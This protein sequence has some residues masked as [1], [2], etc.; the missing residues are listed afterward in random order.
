MEDRLGRNEFFSWQ[1]FR[2][3]LDAWCE[4]R[5]VV[6]TVRHCVLLNDD[7]VCREVAQALKYSS[8]DLG[9]GNCPLRKS[10]PAVIKLRL[11]LRKDRLIVIAANLQH[12]HRT[13]EAVPEQ[14]MKRNRLLHPAALAN[15]ISKKFLD[16]HDLKRLLRSPPEAF[17]DG[18]QV[19]KDL[20]SLFVSDPKA[21]VKLVFIEDKLLVK[22]IFVMVSYMQEV[23]QHF[24]ASLYVDLLPEFCKE[25]D[26]YTAFC[27]EDLSSWKICA[28]CIARKGTQGILRF[29]LVSI[30]Q[31]IPK[32]NTQVKHITLSPEILDP[33][34]LAALL[35]HASIRY[36]MPLVLDLLQQ[37]ISHPDP[38][39]GDEMKAILHVLLNT[40]SLEVYYQYL[41]DLK[42]IC[43]PELY[44]FYYDIWHSRRQMW[45][46][47]DVRTQV[48]EANIHALARWK[49]QAVKSQLCES[50]TLDQCLQVV[51]RDGDT[52]FYLVE[53]CQLPQSE[54]M[55]TQ[56]DALAET[57]EHKADQ[58]GDL[59]KEMDKAE[60]D[61]D[62]E[63][64]EE[65]FTQMNEELNV[66]V[67]QASEGTSEEQLEQSEFYSWVDF[68]SFLDAWCLERS[69]RFAI[70]QSVPLSVEKAG[71]VVAHS[72]KYETVSMGC[73]GSS[74]N[75]RK[76]CPATIHLNLGPQNDKLIVSKTYLWHNHDLKETSSFTVGA[77]QKLMTHARH[78]TRLALDI[79]RKF[80]EW[81]D[82]SRLLRFHS[83][84]FEEHSQILKELDSLFVSDP[85]I[86]VKL[87]F[88]EEQLLVKNIFIMTSQMQEL[89]RAFPEHL[90]VDF[91]PNLHPNFDLYTV[92]CEGENSH[93]VVCAYCISRKE[94]S[95][96]LRFSMVSIMQS[97]P[98]MS[99]QVKYVTVGP[100]VRDPQ[101][102]ETLV[103]NASVKYCVQLV[104]DRL[105]QS[106]A[107]V[108]SIIGTK[109]KKCV[110]NL[111]QTR[112][113]S[114]YNRYLN[115]LRAVCPVDI[116]NYYYSTWH[117][118]WKMWSRAD[119][120]SQDSESRIC[121]LV[122]AK[123]ERLTAHS[124]PSLHYCLQM[125]LHDC[126]ALSCLYL[127]ETNLNNASQIKSDLESPFVPASLNVVDKDHLQESVASKESKDDGCQP[128]LIKE[129]TEL[130]NQDSQQQCLPLAS[131][132]TQFLPCQET[133][134]HPAHETISHPAHESLP[135]TDIETLPHFTHQPLPLPDRGSMSHSL[136][137]P[138][139]QPTHDSLPPSDHEPLPPHDVEPLPPGDIAPLPPSDS[140]TM[141]P[142]Y[143]EPMIDSEQ[144]LQPHNDHLL[145]SHEVPQPFPSKKQVFLPQEKSPVV[146]LDE[147]PLCQDPQVLPYQEPQP[148]LLQEQSTLGS[149]EHEPRSPLE[150][151]SFSSQHAPHKETHSVSSVAPTNANQCHVYAVTSETRLN[152]REFHS[153]D[154]FCSFLDNCCEEKFVVRLSENLSEEDLNQ[155]Q[156]NSELAQSLKYSSAELSCCRMN[157]PAFI[158]LKLGRQKDRLVVAES[159]F[160]HSHDFLNTDDSPAPK[161]S[162]LSTHVGLPAYIA[163]NIS[164]KFLEPA[165]LERL[166]RFRSSAFE[167]RTQ[168]LSELQ[169]LFISDPK[170]RIKLVFV[171]DKFL[172]KSIFVMTSGMQDI[173]RIFSGHLC[174]DFFP[175]FSP[176]FDLYTVF[177]EGENYGWNVCA[178]C[179]SKKSLLDILRFIMVSIFQTIPCM[180][181]IVERVIVHPGIQVPWGL[182]ALLPRALIHYC[183][184]S[185][186]EFLQLKI[187][188]CD[189]NA[190][191]QVKSC[192]TVLTHTKSAEV[193][194]KCLSE[195]KVLCPAEV[196]QYYIETWHPH[197]NQWLH[198]GEIT[199]ETEKHVYAFV[200]CKHQAFIAQMGHAPSLHQCLHVVLNDGHKIC[201]RESSQ[202]EKVDTVDSYYG[203]ETDT[204]EHVEHQKTGGTNIPLVKEEQMENDVEMSLAFSS[205][206]SGVLTAQTK[207]AQ[208]LLV[209][210]ENDPGM[211]MD[212]SAFGANVQTTQ[213]SEV[214]PLVKEEKI[215]QTSVDSSASVSDDWI[216][217]AGEM[218]IPLIKEETDVRTSG[219]ASSSG[220]DD[221][222]QQ[223]GE[224]IIPLIKEETDVRTSGDA[225][226]SVADDHLQQALRPAVKDQLEGSEFHSWNE[227]HSFLDVWCENRKVEFA[228]IHSVAFTEKEINEYVR[229]PEIAESLR[230]S[231]VHLGCSR[232]PSCPA[233]IE[234][235]LSPFKDKLVV[236]KTI[237]HNHELSNVACLPSTRRITRSCM[238]KVTTE[239]P[240]RIANDISKTFLEPVDLKRL[241]SLDSSTFKDC[242]EVLGELDSLFI[243]DPSAKVKLEYAEG[244]ALVNNIFIM[245]SHMQDIVQRWPEHLYVDILPLFSP[246]FDL[247]MVL[248]KSSA[249]PWSVCACCI[250][251]TCTPNT[252]QFIVLSVMQSMPILKTLVKYLTISPEIQDPLD[253]KSIVP[254]ALIRYCW[255]LVLDLLYQKIAHLDEKTVAQIKN[256]LYILAN[257]RSTK[258]YYKY[259]D[260]LLDICPAEIFQYYMDVWHPRWKFWVKRDSRNEAEELSLQH[261]VHS[262][263]S[264]LMALVGPSPTLHR[265]LQL[266]LNDWHTTSET[267]NPRKPTLQV[268]QAADCLHLQKVDT[269]DNT[270]ALTKKTEDTDEEDSDDD[271]Y[272]TSTESGIFLNEM[273]MGPDEERLDR[274]EFYSWQDFISFLDN[275]SKERK[276]VF[277]I[278]CSTALSEQEIN[279]YPLGPEIARSL[280]YKSVRLGCMSG[281][282]WSCPAFIRLSL[283]L[284][285]DRL[286]VIKT[287]LQHNHEPQCVSLHWK[288]KKKKQVALVELSIRVANDISRKFLELNDIKKLLRYR[289]QPYEEISKL[290]AELKSL[291]E[292][293]P[294]VKIKLVFVEDKGTV[295]DLFIMTSTM[296]E[297]AQNV[298]IHLYVEVLSNFIAGFDLYT[299]L[300][301]DCSR[302]R[303]C[304]YCIT[305]EGT[306]DSLLFTLVSILQSI[307]KINMQV[308]QITVSPEIQDGLDLEKLVPYAKVSYCTKSVLKMLYQKVSHLDANVQA[309]IKDSLLTLAHTHSASLYS[310]SLNDLVA[311]CP[312]DIFQ[313]YYDVWHLRRKYWV[314]EDSSKCNTE[315]SI[316]NTLREQQRKFV[317]KVG[318]IPYLYQS[319]HLILS[320]E[321]MELECGE[322][323]QLLE[324]NEATHGAGM[325]ESS[326]VTSKAN[327]S[328][329]LLQGMEFPSWNTF[330]EFFDHWCEERKELYLIS[331]AQPLKKGA[332]N[333]PVANLKYRYV[334]LVC[335]KSCGS[336]LVQSSTGG[337]TSSCPAAITLRASKD[338]KCLVIVQTRTDHDHNTSAVECDQQ[339]NQPHLA[340]NHGLSAW[341]NTLCY[342]FL[343]PQSVQ[344]LLANEQALNPALCECLMELGSLFSLDPGAKVKLTFLPDIVTL[345]SV[346]LMT[347]HTKNLL[348]SFPTVLFLGHSLAIN[349]TFDLYTVLCED[350]D[351]RGR[352]CAY[353]ITREKSQNPIRFM[354]VWLLRGV[355]GI[356]AHIEGLI[357]QANLKELDLIR[358]L[359]PSCCVRMSQTHALDTMYRRASLEEPT[360]QEQLK[361]LVSSVVHARTPAIY[362]SCFRQL[363][364]AA[365][366]AF[367]RYFI[368]A[369]HGRREDWVE[370]WG[371]KMRDG[372]F[373]EFAAWEPGE[374]RS[375]GSFPCPLSS[376]IHALVNVTPLQKTEDNS[377]FTTPEQAVVDSACCIQESMDVSTELEK[378][379]PSLSPDVLI[380][381]KTSRHEGQE[382]SHDEELPDTGAGNFGNATSPGTL[383]AAATPETLRQISR[384]SKGLRGREFLSWT[385][386]SDFFDAWCEKKRM[387]YK[388]KNYTPLDKVK[389][390]NHVSAST[391]LQLR[392]SYVRFICKNAISSLWSRK[393]S[394]RDTF[395]CPSHIILRVGPNFDC[396]YIEQAMLEHNHDISEEEFAM[397]YPQCRLKANPYF[398]LKLT[399]SVSSQFVTL[400]DLQKLMERSCDEQADLQHLVAELLA[401][402]E[403]DSKTKVKL[404]FYPDEVELECVFLM[405]SRMR[406]LIQR[407]PSILFLDRSLSVNKNFNL[408]TVLCE[409]AD[410]RGRECAYFLTHKDSQTPVRF[411]MV[412]LM[413]SIPGTLKPHIK[414][415]VIHTDLAELDLISSLLP[416]RTVVMSQAYALESLYSRVDQEDPSVHQTLKNIIQK[417]V[418][419]PTPKAFEFHVKE[420]SAVSLAGFFTYFMDNW[421]HRK[422]MWVACWGLKKPER[423]RFSELVLHHQA[424]LRSA[425]SP[426]MTPAECV[427]GLMRLQSLSVLTATLNEDKLYALYQSACPPFGLKLVQEEISLSKQGCYEVTELE[428]GFVLNDGT[429]DFQIDEELTNCSCSIYTYSHL[430]CRHLFAARLWAGEPV[431]DLKLIQGKK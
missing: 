277:V 407:F 403:L 54:E 350:A 109:I 269:I 22:S 119:N 149:Y 228:N 4:V 221:Q 326:E 189:V 394:C 91:L 421:H 420:L 116:F 387:L 145:L 355:P 294:F 75:T 398:L 58:I 364:A 20:D 112:T 101:V 323:V 136:Y 3:F 246:G 258:L 66:D 388:I 315:D 372:H 168:V 199:E 272:E 14:E 365:P 25:F 213:A 390:P 360:V 300:C 362:R 280:R 423:S 108:D 210:Q 399:N 311:F 179:I 55:L 142:S 198:R 103:P 247:Y 325:Y 268:R 49:H 252:L 153:W 256:F 296:Q 285:Q 87:V 26:L 424:M 303:V 283:G 331:K 200:K 88:L 242:L 62:E 334:Q 340:T 150:T 99:T 378:S 389:K 317:N 243:S 76:K 197:R 172:V 249:V 244:K 363:E 132:D 313:Y 175:D 308:N 92:L 18:I 24:P 299:V 38:T 83:I 60:N 174:V 115:D 164:R 70:R 259:L 183:V 275:W 67:G 134:P 97:I 72:L 162:R 212:I 281:T 192:L 128:L 34:D 178:Q 124:N 163:N 186:F 342:T 151:K 341:I 86:K 216:Q 10:C 177:C 348:N 169:S 357:V 302:W 107:H 354:L 271:S 69:T 290:V 84:P 29:I 405:T 356:K 236:T 30:M 11:G 202:Q 48:K 230:Y 297:I 165:D 404:V 380:P 231:E 206:D 361:K 349:E 374:L 9:C 204:T 78:T 262:E 182:E 129:S 386:F 36:C 93:W 6:F 287:V 123:H 377:W 229:G 146:S 193:Y 411:M 401:L 260:I 130:R 12:N 430:P 385:E 61:K 232:Y 185:L 373:L 248:C 167:D 52:M 35:P 152:G 415:V 100:D 235:K 402:F 131:I 82:L 176:G 397:H 375:T 286:I 304:A 288:M 64:K 207:C 370:S 270:H 298:P 137:Q 266:V 27:E 255:P 113:L 223:A 417:L 346:F 309:R 120:S 28:Y 133:L 293:D 263:H 305:K 267:N 427:S 333:D 278:R 121:E 8:V 74:L 95:D 195:L 215:V 46:K 57:V 141:P 306:S 147:S 104:L 41:N 227:F 159:S 240:N 324:T 1:D 337:T 32:M 63:Q 226:T 59:K 102:L 383:A 371:H 239:H 160:Q 312:V 77:A 412:S 289:L 359:I 68:C 327:N 264:A 429:S 194:E 321:F 126:G 332:G 155:M 245:T 45:V 190:E 322:S 170:A 379:S 225:S 250:A 222:I 110:V 307:P 408:Y 316:Y 211:F 203:K 328:T 384:R 233:A 368:Q 295:K 19:L 31:S 254:R 353:F 42:T 422:K 205:N 208:F 2:T 138:L 96:S 33:L 381:C 94:T 16:T 154:V 314:Q 431:F 148:L 282:R 320:K 218:I 7:G 318:P 338:K 51:L 396:L 156:H 251:R 257:T 171:E 418:F 127:P 187:T 301:D 336:H 135:Q 238:Q 158:K 237:Q 166:L 276:V 391:T 53:F 15:D 347:S 284:Q 395:T 157:C 173:A 224:M 419:A 85:G 214:I 65:A 114:I 369:W 98:K 217:Q 81:S 426:P 40:D 191:A 261:F 273:S 37:N 56:Q 367:L 13:A 111:S 122:K 319:L 358:D 71:A 105:Y 410:G 140:A 21:K 73:Q 292:A 343:T 144:V 23:A 345:E 118:C 139:P 125:I 413:Q 201:M 241:R 79:S 5:K 279:H 344:E 161:K 406:C 291:L 265:S 382:C 50:P 181:S 352:E 366:S 310:H 376:C 44:Q 184:P 196:I 409:D 274:S 253:L 209:K 339:L 329:A 351:G 416:N 117:P 392:Y 393:Q 143:Y 90:Y 234:L 43:P 89:A 80:L 428:Q 188:P 400:R 330:C 425:L 17:G 335:K 47:E 219:D 106:I 39:T 220:A 414:S 180:S